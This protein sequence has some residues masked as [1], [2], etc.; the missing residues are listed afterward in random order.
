MKNQKYE[1]DG[2]DDRIIDE[3]TVDTADNEER[4]TNGKVKS[5]ENEKESKK[6]KSDKTA[7]SEKP[8]ERKPSFFFRMMPFFFIVIALVLTVSFLFWNKDDSGIFGYIVN[9]V[10][11][12]VLSV[13]AWIVPVLLVN[14]AVFWNSDYKKYATKRK[15]ICTL[16]AIILLA[17]INYYISYVINGEPESMGIASIW[18]YA[19]RENGF[20]YGGIVGAYFGWLLCKIFERIL[21]PIILGAGLT[22][23]IVFLLNVSPEAFTNSM[24][25]LLKKI[26][27]AILISLRFIGLCILKFVKWLGRTIARF[28]VYLFKKEKIYEDE[29]NVASDDD[30]ISNNIKNIKSE[31]GSV[32]DDSGDKSVKDKKFQLSDIFD[33]NKVASGENGKKG[34]RESDG[35]DKNTENEKTVV[36]V[37]EGQSQQQAKIFGEDDENNVIVDKPDRITVVKTSLMSENGEDDETDVNEYLYPPIE[38]LQKKHGTVN[39]SKYQKEC[40]EMGQTLIDVLKSFNVG[41]SLVGISIGPTITRY[42]LLP[43]DGVRVR[44]I[45]NLSND[46][47]LKL[48][49][50]KAIRIEAPIPGKT[51]VGIEVASPIRRTVYLSE[52]LDTPAFRNAESKLTSVVGLDIAGNPIYMDLAKMPHLLIAGTTGS[53]KSV[54]MNCIILSLLYKSTPDEVK[55]IMIDP[56]KVEFSVY[57]GLPHLVVPVVTDYKEAA[58]TLKWAEIEM[59]RRYNLIRESRVRDVDNYNRKNAGNPEKEYMPKLVIFI[60]ELAELMMKAS[61]ETVEKSISSLAQKGRACGIHLIVGTQRPSVDVITGL[62][63]ANIPSRIAFSV[64]SQIDSRTIIDCAGAETLLGKGDMLYSPMESGGSAI[65]VQGGFVTDS[66]VEN[67][68]EFI[69][70]NNRTVEYN[71]DIINDIKSE[72]EKCIKQK[73]KFMPDDEQ[74]SDGDKDKYL[75]KAINDPKFIEAVELAMDWGK[76][77]TSLMQRKLGLGYGKTAR[78]IDAMEMLGIVSGANGTKPRELIMSREEWEEFKAAHFKFVEDEDDDE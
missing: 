21:T 53:G 57:E 55:L 68:V 51:A 13:V 74:I 75:E 46:I 39:D 23:C 1:A 50:K 6:G 4:K 64:S 48:A 33:E 61:K 31:T 9:K 17:A 63:K 67:I 60:D 47:A 44:Q 3:D 65:R 42:E 30:G 27:K 66:E 70:Q 18:N 25:N 28:I 73:Q 45:A 29:E 56:K 12:G 59:D 24:L 49:A 58:G 22:V 43:N 40:Q 15:I 77:A 36:V 11:Y 34:R 38:F 52:L 14:L 76:I 19:Q 35:S 41:T 71:E 62:I 20:Q 2:T 69:L 32:T 7:S 10:L 72:A 5:A 16:C 26:G 37:A 54:C 78:L 8:K